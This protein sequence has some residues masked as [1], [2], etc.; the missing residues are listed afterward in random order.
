M[1]IRNKLFSLMAAAVIC[2][3][4]AAVNITR[5]Y[6][7]DYEI[8]SHTGWRATVFRDRDGTRFAGDAYYWGGPVDTP[9]DV[10]EY[11]TY[12]G[13]GIPVRNVRLSKTCE[14]KTDYD[15]TFNVPDGV[16]I[17]E[18]TSFLYDHTNE[19]ITLNYSDGTTE[20]V[21]HNYTSAM[22]DYDTNVNNWDYE[23]LESLDGVYDSACVELTAYKGNSTMIAVPTEI[24]GLPVVRLS[25]TV[26]EG[27]GTF[28]NVSIAI[29]NKVRNNGLAF[30]EEITKLPEVQIADGCFDG[31]H[32]LSLDFYTG[33]RY[34]ES[35]PILMYYDQRYELY[36]DK[37]NPSGWQLCS[38][39]S[40]DDEKVV[41]PDKIG[42]IEVESVNTSVLHSDHEVDVVLPDTIRKFS[43][44]AFSSSML[45]SINIPENVKVIPEYC[46]SDCPHLTEVTNTDHVQLISNNAFTSL[47]S[48]DSGYSPIKEAEKM[49]IFNYNTDDTDIPFIV[50][51]TKK[52]LSYRIY[53]NTEDNT[54]SAKLIY[55]PYGIEDAP[56]DLNGI[57]V[58]IQLENKVPKGT[59]VV[60]PE[61]TSELA[62]KDID[63]QHDDVFDNFGGSIPEYLFELQDIFGDDNTYQRGWV[64]KVDILSKDIFI[65]NGAL[66]DYACSSFTFPGSVR[67]GTNFNARNIN[68]TE[69]IF[70]G[71]GAVINIENNACKGQYNLKKLDFAGKCSSLRIGTTA[72]ADSGIRK[73]VLPENT[74]FIGSGAFQ[75]SIQLTDVTIN[76]SPEIA[77][78]A[79]YN[80]PNLQNVTINGSPILNAEIFSK[81]N[82]LK[83]I[84]IN[85][86]AEIDGSIFNNCLE[87]CSINDVRV[88]DN[89]EAPSKEYMDFIERNFK[90][91]ENNGI[92]NGYIA[93]M[94]KKTVA[95]TVDDSMTDV[96]KIKAIHDKICSMVDYDHE[97][98]DAIKN[99]TDASVFLNDTSVCDGYARAMNLMLHE[100]GVKSQYVRTE[101]HAWVIVNVG[102]HYFHVDPTWDDDGAEI[103]YDWFMKSDTEIS[104]MGSHSQWKAEVPSKLHEFQ[105]KTV[106][107]CTS[108]MGDVDEN[109]MVDGVDASAILSAYAELSV[110]GS[111]DIDRVL[112]DYNF[113]GRI[114]AVDASLVITDYAKSSVE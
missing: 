47:R 90:D 99:H 5:S 79:F 40:L 89:G 75:D 112:A 69:L 62:L 103:C 113:D 4:T 56:A 30:D 54:L 102:G 61:D 36:S 42:G 37:E 63:F 55:A 110:E 1:K 16:K 101:D 33:V 94:V 32:N 48:S 57:P 80:C 17:E 104:D 78:R 114:N 91:S 100:A 46:F 51:D 34:D 27:K 85:T 73:L 15:I 87:L 9:I 11:L 20:R 107:P 76:G 72:F 49:V 105:N 41:I 66:A 74:N 109:G 95:E 38:I 67:L 60:I 14:N 21:E 31:M 71:D 19:K 92:I 35:P 106:P 8:I 86:D 18:K 58:E 24:D 10:P 43:P 83:N 96:Q 68:L 52:D 81:C 53:T 29:I 12:E 65:R 70:N 93:Y 23:V 25:D 84:N 28:M 13:D 111:S 22:Y 108:V 44:S 88:F 6:E 26:F 3:N 97:D 39:S 77:K 98:K 45:R 50:T 64:N 2:A 7:E 82:K 59:P